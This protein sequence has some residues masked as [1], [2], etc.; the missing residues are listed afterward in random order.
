MCMMMPKI[1]VNA[2]KFRKNSSR[3]CRSNINHHLKWRTLYT[4]SL[5]TV[6]TYTSCSAFMQILL[7]K[8][9]SF[10]PTLDSNFLFEIFETNHQALSGNGGNWCKYYSAKFDGEG[11]FHFQK[12]EF[13]LFLPKKWKQFTSKLRTQF[14]NTASHSKIFGWLKKWVEQGWC[15]LLI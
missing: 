11:L 1:S 9:L 8:K 5:W 2:W 14:A 3:R 13:S 15:R 12:D 7:R 4:K 6:H 10:L